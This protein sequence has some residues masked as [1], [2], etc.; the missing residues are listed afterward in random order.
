MPPVRPDSSQRV[1]M[2]T[3]ELRRLEELRKWRSNRNCPA[4]QICGSTYTVT[5]V[6]P[7]IFGRGALPGRHSVRE[8]GGTSRVQALAVKRLF[9]QPFPANVAPTL[10]PMR[11]DPSYDPAVESVEER[12]D[13][14][15]FVTFEPRFPIELTKSTGY[16]TK[17]F[18][19]SGHVH[20][21]P[22]G[23]KEQ[24]RHR[25]HGGMPL[26]QQTLQALFL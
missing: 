24:F 22:N 26:L 23:Q 13:V 15:A 25:V 3:P 21:A 8:A 19:S 11:P 4:G 14:G 6:D 18:S 5:A 16:F 17:P 10:I 2:L 9:G 1:R 7:C 12:S 20:V